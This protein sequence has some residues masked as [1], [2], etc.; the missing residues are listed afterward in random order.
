MKGRPIIPSCPPGPSR[1]ALYRHAKRALHKALVRRWTGSRVGLDRHIRAFL[2][3]RRRSYLLRLVR[4]HAFALA[5]ATALLTGATAHAASPIELS[6]IAIAANAGGFVMNGETGFDY[7]G[8]SVSGAGDVNGDGL[9]D[10]IV[11]AWGADP[12][13]SF[14]GTSYVVFGKAS[15]T[16]VELSA[17]A[18]GTGGFAINGEAMEDESGFSVSGAGDV[19]G[20]GLDDLIVGAYG[21]DPNGS[22]SGTSYVVFGKAS[23]TTVELSAIAAGTG[24][25]AINGETGFDFS[26]H[27]ASGAGDVNGDGLDD[28]IVGA[29]RAS[30]NGYYSGTSYVVFGKASGTTVELSAIAAGTGGFAINGETAYDESGWSVAGAGDVNGDGLDD[31]IV[32][33]YGAD[34]NGDRSG[35]SYVVFGKADGT[36]VELSAIA[37]GTGGFAINGETGG[38]WSGSSVSGAG[39]VNGDGLDD[40]IVGAAYAD[41]NGNHSGTSYVVFGKASGTT[42]ELSAIAA[43]TGGFAMNGEAGDDRSGSSVS[44]AGDVNGD[45]L[46]DLIVGAFAADPNG[47][48]SGT[49]YVVFS[50]EPA[51]GRKLWV[52]FAHSGVKE[53]T[54]PLPYD[55]VLEALNAVF[56]GGV[57]NIKG[58]TADSDSPEV[59]IIDQAVTLN[60]IGGTVTIGNPAARDARL[61]TVEDGFVSKKR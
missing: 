42:V 25:F 23:G 61:G 40:L 60:A 13:G 59:L 3:G 26:G 39:D 27:S 33:A 18:A 52:D 58:N 19:N 47:S 53:G 45:G 5:V 15:G 56:A 14:S 4:Q 12:N 1:R 20:D 54:H 37:A 50:S 10:F 21:A 22:Y 43:G 55:T 31:L 51:Q 38:D 35:K 2:R 28:L 29:W 8:F 41:P 9:D 24:G 17:I 57:I 34:P 6:D 46:D 11:G 30:P 32:G 7:S 36:T 16:T 49:S 44:G 48:F